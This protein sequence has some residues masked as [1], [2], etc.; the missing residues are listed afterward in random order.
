MT[1]TAK[2][3]NVLREGENIKVFVDF[4]GKTEFFTFAPA[5][6][7]A[8]MRADIKTRLDFLNSIEAKVDALSD[9]VNT[10]IE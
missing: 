4:S 8:D 6:K 2:V 1:I 7:K 5:T 9:L 10:V 3:T